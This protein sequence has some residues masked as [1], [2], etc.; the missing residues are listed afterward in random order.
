MKKSVRGEFSYSGNKKKKNGSFIITLLIR[1]FY[2]LYMKHEHIAQIY[3]IFFQCVIVFNLV[4]NYRCM[5]VARHFG[6]LSENY[7]K[8]DIGLI[9]AYLWVFFIKTRIP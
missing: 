1:L 6:L 3:I 5:H 4:K 2:I 7:Y 9:T 8:R